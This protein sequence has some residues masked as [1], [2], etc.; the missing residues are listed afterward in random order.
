M[1]IQGGTRGLISYESLVLSIF[2]H[3]NAF[4]NL[5]LL[6]LKRIHSFLSKDRV[7]L[8]K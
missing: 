7:F 8:G 2:T 1:V 5:C 3:V 6:A 4:N